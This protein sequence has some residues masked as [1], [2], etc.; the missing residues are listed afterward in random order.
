MK[1]LL[2]ISCLL[3]TSVGWSKDITMDDL[4]IT[5]GLYYEKF[6]EKPFTGSVIGIEQGKISKGKKEGEWLFYHK[7]GRLKYKTIFKEGKQDGEAFKYNKNGQLKKKRN[8]KDGILDG[9]YLIYDNGKK[10]NGQVIIKV[11]YKDGILDDE[12]FHYGEKGNFKNYNLE[13][14]K[15]YIHELDQKWIKRE[16]LR[17]E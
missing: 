10:R 1:Y 7:N 2:I 12:Y 16:L 3:F 8:Y 15:L 13:G 6:T 11:Y 14:E 9:E 17:G 5:D 4:V